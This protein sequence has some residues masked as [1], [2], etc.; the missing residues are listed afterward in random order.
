MTSYS[1]DSDLFRSVGRGIFGLTPLKPLTNDSG[2]DIPKSEHYLLYPIAETLQ[3]PIIIF[4]LSPRALDWEVEWQIQ[5][6][7]ILIVGIM[8][9]IKRPILF[10]PI[11]LSIITSSFPESLQIFFQP[12]FPPCR[13]KPP[14]APSARV[15]PKFP[16]LASVPWGSR[17]SMAR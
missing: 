8:I 7:L 16:P 14:P 6:I 2:R 9:H 11:F 1:V 10:A 13:R 15:G 17:L 5:S 4:F 3:I 12:D